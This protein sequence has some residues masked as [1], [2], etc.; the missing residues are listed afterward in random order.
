MYS[1]EV[2]FESYI[3]NDIDICWLGENKTS[4]YNSVYFF[5]DLY[6]LSRCIC[7]YC[8]LVLI[9]FETQYS[10]IICYMKKLLSWPHKRN[11]FT[12]S[13]FYILLE[14]EI[15]IFF[16]WASYSRFLH[17]YYSKEDLN[18]SPLLFR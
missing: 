8:L 17:S 5:S 13:T 6:F 15:A 11:R 7:V 2:K 14:Y 4:D 9:C 12:Q 3:E 1:T 10:K 16:P 18:D